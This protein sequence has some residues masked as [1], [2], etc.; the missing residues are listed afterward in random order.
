MS[1]FSG[2][3]DVWSSLRTIFYEFS[4]TLQT[5]CAYNLF[6]FPIISSVYYL[7][8]VFLTLMWYLNKRTKNTS[9]SWHHAG[10]PEAALQSCPYGKLFWKICRKFTGEHP[11]RSV[12]SMNLLCNFIEI[13]LWHGCSPVNLL[14][15]LI[16]LFPSNTSRRMLLDIYWLHCDSIP[17]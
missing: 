14:H 16:T 15:I 13:A 10:Y 1:L 8:C 3:Y 9:S 17:I 11:C 12:I 2:V 4:S 5:W 7:Y 6:I